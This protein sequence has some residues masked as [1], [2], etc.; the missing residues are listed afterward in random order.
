MRLGVIGG[1]GPMATAYFIELIVNM[2]DAQND[3]D[4]LDM[5][6]FNCPSIPDRT[7]YI[8]G[9]SKE[10]PVK[11]MAL[12]GKRLAELGADHISIPCITAHY[13]YNDLVRLIDVPILDAVTETAN[14]LKEQGVKKVGILATDGTLAGGLFQDRLSSVGIDHI[15]PSSYAQRG[16]MKIIYDDIKAGRP[17]NIELFGKITRELRDSGAEAII[18]GCTELSLIKR[19][20]SIGAGYIDVMEVLA[21]ASILRCNRLLK[22]QYYSL[23]SNRG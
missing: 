13:F 22:K 21:K 9:E 6:V 4:H 12:I 20:F 16:V 19:D 23:I 1:L 5:I 14:H 3:Q 18:L 2:T 15:I 11:A 8:L 10:S 17:A 7:K